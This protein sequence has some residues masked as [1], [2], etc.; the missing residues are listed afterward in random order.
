MRRRF[1]ALGRHSPAVFRPLATRR[2]FRRSRC[3]P[4]RAGNG[5]AGCSPR[6]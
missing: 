2:L 3:A 5:R 1:S 6:G 4:R